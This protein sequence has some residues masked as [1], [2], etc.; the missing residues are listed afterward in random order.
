MKLE[1]AGLLHTFL[2]LQGFLSEP[3]SFPEAPQV[4]GLSVGRVFPR[5][6]NLPGGPNVGRSL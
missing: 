6:I 3:V 5:H 4:D 2:P 1:E